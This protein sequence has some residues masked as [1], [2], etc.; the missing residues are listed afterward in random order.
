MRQKSALNS[1]EGSLQESSECPEATTWIR[2]MKTGARTFNVGTL[3]PFGVGLLVWGELVFKV[4][5]KG[6]ADG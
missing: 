5:L 3:R 1:A 4:R 2:A 6:A